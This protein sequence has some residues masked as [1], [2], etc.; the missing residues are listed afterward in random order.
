MGR[1]STN[2]FQDE[3]FDVEENV[4]RGKPPA[5]VTLLPK[6]DKIETEEDALAA[7]EQ[8]M[9]ARFTANS[10]SDEQALA[11]ENIVSWAISCIDANDY[12]ILTLGGFAGTGKTTM[13]A[14]LAERLEDYRVAFCSL[15]G[16]AVNVLKQKFADKNVRSGNHTLST[17]HSLLYTPVTNKWGSVI[18]WEKKEE[19]HCDLIVVD[20]G[21]MVSEDILRTFME[22]KIP[23]LAVGDH[24]QLPPVEGRFNLM[25]DPEIK[26]ETIH[27]QAKDSP[28]L[29]LSEELRATGKFPPIYRNTPEVQFLSKAQAGEVLASLYKTPGF[30]LDDLA[31]LCFKNRTRM[32]LNTLARSIRWGKAPEL[33]VIGD[34]IICLRNAQDGLFNGMRGEIGNIVKTTPSHIFG[35]IDFPAEGIR[36]NGAMNK[37]Q[38]GREKVF[39]DLRE[40]QTASGF[41]AFSFGQLG[42]LVD[43][44][45]ALTVHKAQGSELPF[46]V[47]FDDFPH[48]RYTDDGGDY[49]KRWIYTACSRCRKYLVVLQ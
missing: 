38:F 11:F 45:Y 32:E 39:K 24:G 31:L 48:H 13:L 40:Y 5:T 19:L 4:I 47:L 6:F 20:E 27:R 17:I 41:R 33:P 30:K 1:Y 25:G 28:V 16:K 14:A 35:S 18:G 15:T 26:L 37:H 46:V 2:K 36:F 22:F 9:G 8:Q 44:G 49:Y 3:D 12:D 10:L 43:Y 21:S 7:V 42:L 23:L 34:Q 29:A